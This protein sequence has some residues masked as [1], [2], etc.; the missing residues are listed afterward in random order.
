MT[1]IK[2]GVVSR[3]DALIAAGSLVVGATIGALPDFLRDPAPVNRRKIAIGILGQSNEQNRVP[4]SDRKEFPRAFQSQRNQAVQAPQLG[5]L[6]LQFTGSAAGGRT[7]RFEPFGGMWFALYDT[8][9]DWGYDCHF[10]NGAIGSASMSK[11][12]AGTAVAWR[13]N[14]DGYFQARNSIGSGDNGYAGS[15]IIA[16]EPEKIFRCTKGRLHFSTLYGSSAPIP[17]TKIDTLDYITAV[18]TERSGPFEPKWNSVSQTGEKILDGDIEWTCEGVNDTGFGRKNVGVD[19]FNP[20]MGSRFWDPAGILRRLES[21]M[22]PIQDVVEK[23]IIIQNGQSEYGGS[24]S[25]QHLYQSAL[26]NITQFFLDRGYNVAIGLSCFALT[27]ETKSWDGLQTARNEALS[28]FNSRDQ[29][30]SQTGR[31]EPGANLYHDLGTASAALLQKDQVHLNGA[32]ALKAGLSWG[33]AFKKILPQNP[34]E[35]G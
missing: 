27:Q 29:S 13:P 16:G 17:G 34:M 2:S 25:G 35:A 11:D 19:V 20:V 4:P 23:W 33:E 6:V 24:A 31:V 21:L 9:W 3:R 1:W 7:K 26:E 28:S 10:V 30:T 8:L 12:I 18:G 5:N 32:G 14:N 22:S 15:V